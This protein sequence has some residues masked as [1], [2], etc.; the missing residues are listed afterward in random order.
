MFI[1]RKITL[2]KWNPNEE[3]APGEISADA[4][5]ADLRT[6]DNKLS[7]WRCGNGSQTE[8]GE[9]ALAMAA[10]GNRVDKIELAWI[11]EDDLR[12]D[13]QLWLDTEG[14]TPVEQLAS[15][16]LDVCRLDYVRLGKIAHRVADAIKEGRFERL[17]KERVLDILVAAIQQRRLEL[18]DLKDKVRAEVNKSLA[19]R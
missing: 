9:V 2:A 8:I 4:V 14:R 5:T 13:G 7:F 3:L 18:N 10:T 6:Q 1:A 16:H 12:A 17:K 15:R 19:T 11:P